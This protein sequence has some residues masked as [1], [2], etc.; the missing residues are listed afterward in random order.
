[1]TVKKEPLSLYFFSLLYISFLLSINN[2]LYLKLL[3][4]VIVSTRFAE[5]IWKLKLCKI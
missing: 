1:M 5:I 3:F 4:R 2:I